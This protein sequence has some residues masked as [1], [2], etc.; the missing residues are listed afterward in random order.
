MQD[1]GHSGGE[2]ML[3]GQ[4]SAPG[5]MVVLGLLVALLLFGLC[6]TSWA[7]DDS[8]SAPLFIEFDY[9]A[10]EECLDRERVFSLVHRRSRR[11]TL[12]DGEPPTQILVMQIEEKDG[13][14]FGILSVRRPEQSEE[15][16]TM[17][18]TRCD[19]VVE[20]L[21]LTAALSIDPNAT[22]MLDD[23]ESDEHSEDRGAPESEAP[24]ASSV[25]PVVLESPPPPQVPT[26]E[27][28]TPM[29]WGL[30]VSLLTQR[31]MNHTLHVGGGADIVVTKMDGRHFF[32]LEARLAL[33]ALIE[34]TSA[35]LAIRTRLYLTSLSYCP[36][37]WGSRQAVLFCPFVQLGVIRA[38][39]H[40]FSTEGDATRSFATIGAEASFRALLSDD[41]QMWVTPAIVAP[42]TERDFGIN[43]GPEIL[44]STVDLGFNLSFGLGY[45]F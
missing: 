43:P 10:P 33:R 26:R 5:G 12:S 18:G 31:I 1:A 17:A 13:E 16:R 35:P 34:P 4:E 19:E 41:V 2:S 9:Q 14:F 24:E 25:E 22:L 37:R 40:G 11:V 15:R 7:E 3:R 42:L 20:A 28:D 44:A 6:E 45:T 8:G 29:K 36:L 27:H 32:P 39:S 21:A 23:P 30:G 38:S